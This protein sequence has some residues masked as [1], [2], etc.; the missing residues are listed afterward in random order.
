MTKKTNPDLAKLRLKAEGIFDK[1]M[2]NDKKSHS[3]VD[4]LKLIHELE[5]YHIELEMQ[6][7]ELQLSKDQAKKLATEKY[8]KL[9]DFAPS[10][11]FTLSKK[12]EI[13]ELNLCGSKMLGKERV[14]LKNSIFGFFVSVETRPIFNLFLAN[15][16]ESNK[17]QTCELVIIV[18][19]KP[20]LHLHLTGITCEDEEQCL[21]TG[22]DITEQK[23][24]QNALNESNEYYRLLFENS[25]EA[26]FFTRSDGT[27][28]SANPE[29]CRISGRSE[30]EIKNLGRAGIIDNS[31]PRLE[32]SLEERSRTG[33]FRGEL[34]FL[35]KD[36]SSFP[37]EISTL[38][39][40]DIR[41][42][43]RT[44][45][46]ARDITDRKQVEAKVL[47]SEKRYR[48]LF[49]S[50]IE[51]FSIIEMIF[52]QN[53]NPVDYRFLETNAAYE[54]QTGVKDVVGK[55]V[56]DLTPDMEDFW[57]ETYGRVALTGQ[58]MR[59]ENEAKALN[60]WFQVCAFRVGEE[61]S[62]KVAVCFSD[63]TDR[64]KAEESL[65]INNVRLNLAMQTGNMAWWEMDILTGNVS[66]AKQKAE[67]LGY[68]PEDFKN[69]RDFMALVHP[70]D[71]ESCM[72]A[73]RLHYQGLA[74]KYEVDYRIL[75][76]SGT[77][78][79]CSDIGIVTKHDASGKPLSITGV[80]FNID[81]H[82]LAEA[83]IMTN[84]ARL[85]LAMKVSNM[86]WW[87]MNITTGNIFFEKRKAEMLGYC[88]ENF[89]HYKDFMVLVHPEDAPRAMDAMRRHIYGST[90]KY[91]VEYRIMSKSGE[92]KWFYDIGSITKRDANGKGMLAT[93]IVTNITE[94]KQAEKLL[95]EKDEVLTKAQEIGHLGSWTLDLIKNELTWSEEIYRIFGLKNTEF[96]S[97][98]EGF[99]DTIHPGDR[100][101]ANLVFTNSILEGKP[102]YNMEHRIIRKN[103]GEIRYVWV[104]GENV[105]DTLGKVV[106]SVG[107]VL[108]I[109]ERKLAEIALR[110]SDEKVRFKLQSI[111][112]PEGN[113]AGLELND[114]IDGPTLQKLMENFYELIQI[115]IAIIDNSGK[116]LVSA[117]WQDICTK[118]HRV[119]PGSCLNCID[120]DIHLTHSI[121]DG[122]FKLYKCKNNM[123]DLATPLIIG[124]EHKGN[125]FLGQFFFDN[126][127]IDYN[128]F[129]KQ[130]DRYGFAEQEYM[131]ALDKA[132]RLNQQKLDHAK[133]FFLNLSRSISQLS[134]GNIKLARAI[135]QQKLIERA[136][137]KLSEE[138]EQRVIERTDQLL[139]SNNTL[140]K[141]EEKYR[142]VADFTYDWEY[143]INAEGIFIYVSPS[144]KRISG[145][146]AKEF[147]DDPQLLSRIIFN[148]DAK[149]WE[150]HR[151]D[152][153][154][155]T[156]DELSS[157]FNIRIV[158]KTGDIR[159]IGCVYQKI[160]VAGN[161]L[162]IRGS[163]RDI[164]DKINTDN[165]LLDI[166][167]KVEERERNHFSR[168]LHDGL[169][170]LLSTVKLYF[171]W[172]AETNNSE[173]S[174][175]ITEK[176]NQYIESAIQTTREMAHGL[177]SLILVHSGYVQTVLN[178][179]KTI[180]E[181][182]KLNVD[183]IYNSS[184]R[185]GHLL[186]T[187]LYRITTELINNT[188]KH[189][190]AS[191]IEIELNY[192]KELFLVTFSYTD[193]G[194]GFD[195]TNTDKN[196]NGLGLLNIQYRVDILKG[197]LQ[198]ETSPG[199]GLKISIELPVVE[200]L[201]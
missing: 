5:L 123:W 102:I 91:E 75:T 173:K 87:E 167:L 141:T 15:I 94:R 1:K 65:R 175:I 39:F 155:S 83:E 76:K 57:F 33:R 133:A 187:T 2:V 3:E 28:Y 64:K 72:N 124:G 49:N 109:T 181:T 186:E 198:I 162:G 30:D 111:L 25:G 178:Y 119:H 36:G 37:A 125:L 17:A 139:S 95:R 107:M 79:W 29:A 130:A 48:D 47:Q 184:E 31:D 150:S 134:Y 46:M 14:T 19:D 58:L 170:P 152:D 86:A 147:I 55:L 180:Q 105:K 143:W 73:M 157:E 100:D 115:P 90:D 63:I 168:E 148:A 11:F 38:N 154:I 66:F 145:Y 80:A 77:Y 114:I 71:N 116:V 24:A 4:Q 108:D 183:F 112:L 164:T 113:I 135:T 35:R 10:G 32:A 151:I 92:Y 18:N 44:S 110:K 149:I 51:G 179:A 88:A 185:F 13:R 197:K 89:T 193:N 144:C 70:D 177:S 199:T 68:A 16:F 136:L 158:T 27:I 140:R 56:R 81:K 188:I 40:K 8:D 174:K 43:D 172:L 78:I 201:N 21:V 22:V 176:G 50:M 200:L 99:L 69:Y 195:L 138:L 101:A 106:R 131:V 153:P 192:Q 122:E 104:S 165:A 53:N 171:Q 160:F 137:K 98:Y 146:N 127:I 117:G 26:I 190:K 161:F 191:N 85:S 129:R 52:D 45:I 12:G 103:S 169:G 142:T 189:A 61:G 156:S 7:H 6:N 82:K 120:S 128:L 42:Y 84:N 121:A 93:G 132:P 97:N 196:K 60:K 34:N 54:E 41:G 9:Y 194:I 62:L 67:M 166:T 96:P 74:A 159:W 126:E 118:F 163:N 59:F 23:I 182:Q 20:V